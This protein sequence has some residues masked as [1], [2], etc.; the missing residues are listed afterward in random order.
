MQHGS[1]NY[2]SAECTENIKLKRQV[3]AC[4]IRNQGKFGLMESGIPLNI[5]IQIQVLLTKT[6]Q[7]RN[8]ES[9]IRSL[10]SRIQDCL[11]FPYIGR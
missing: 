9:A 5:G 1:L 4:G 11:E 2:L 3:F 6:M 10:E 8:L 7:S